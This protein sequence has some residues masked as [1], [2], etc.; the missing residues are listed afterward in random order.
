MLKIPI[1]YSGCQSWRLDQWHFEKQCRKLKLQVDFTVILLLMP[2]P[3]EARILPALCNP[4]QSSHHSWKWK[5]KIH[6][7]IL[8][9][10][11]LQNKIN[12]DVESNLIQLNPGSTSNI[13]LH[14]VIFA[15]NILCPRGKLAS[16]CNDVQFK[17]NCIRKPV[18]LTS[19]CQRR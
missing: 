7:S 6:S 11:N 2:K 16:H 1:I 3:N 17:W 5:G 12:Q 9:Q 13:I 19:V 18:T 14:F 10:E 15:I 4:E 8:K